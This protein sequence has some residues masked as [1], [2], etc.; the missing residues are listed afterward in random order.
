MKSDSNRRHHRCHHIRARASAQLGERRA[1]HVEDVQR[2]VRLVE[3]A[4]RLAN[5][6]IDVLAVRR[7]GRP[8]LLE[9]LTRRVGRLHRL[10]EI[11]AGLDAHADP[12]CC[13]ARERPMISLQKFCST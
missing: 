12:R 2:L 4:P 9:L 1:A 3:R 8:E 6:R 7:H 13:Q 5:S 10:A 11:V